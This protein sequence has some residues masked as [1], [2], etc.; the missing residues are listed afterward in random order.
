MIEYM[1]ISN[2]LYIICEM[3]KKPLEHPKDDTKLDPLSIFAQN[4]NM[5]NKM[6]K[7]N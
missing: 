4:Q 6:E 1:L 3:T 7:G 5:G 2:I